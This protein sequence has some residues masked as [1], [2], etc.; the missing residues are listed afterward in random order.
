MKQLLTLFLGI[1]LGISCWGKDLTSRLGVG[2]TNQFTTSLPAITARY[3]P[4][5]QLGFSAALGV[6]T[7]KNAS[8]FGF[9]AKLYRVIFQEENMNFF[10]GAGAGILS[11]ENQGQ[12]SSGFELGGF[13]GGEYFFTGLSSLGFS[14]EAGVGIVSISDGV[15]FRTTGQSPLNAGIIFYF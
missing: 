13:I 7:E 9:L 2:Y 6:D 15:R 8:K 4:N 1:I 12:N 3:Y 14:F 11:M 5:D 10:M